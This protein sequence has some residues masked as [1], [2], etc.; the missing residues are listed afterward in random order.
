MVISWSITESER[1][2][3]VNKPYVTADRSPQ[4]SPTTERL[5]LL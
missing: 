3:P 4:R 1:A 2:S 5:P